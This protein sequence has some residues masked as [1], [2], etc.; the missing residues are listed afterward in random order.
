M[1]KEQSAD[2]MIYLAASL[3]DGFLADMEKENYPFVLLGGVFE[4]SNLPLVKSDDA[5]GA[6]IATQHLISL[7]HKRIGHIAGN[8]A[9]SISRDRE[10]GYRA[11]MK[12]AGLEV[13]PAWV[14]AGDFD[15]DQ[16][17]KQTAQL[18]EQNVTAI[19]AGSDVMAYGAMRALRRAGRRIPEDVA[20][21]GMD[22]LDLSAWMNPSLSTVRY[23]I[24]KLGEIAAAYALKRIE[25]PSGQKI[26]IDDVPVP[27][28]IVRDSCGQKKSA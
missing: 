14:V 1:L 19:F 11:A 7:G 21:V 22:D 28:L 6:K 15:L 24:R 18:V 5:A 26:P 4:K 23:D 17:E 25:V 20:V 13:A 10:Q 12:A 9:Y 8:S 27:E 2:A 16:A 3:Q